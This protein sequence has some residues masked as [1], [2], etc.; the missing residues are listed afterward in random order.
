[1]AYRRLFHDRFVAAPRVGCRPRRDRASAA[2]TAFHAFCWTQVRPAR[3]A[4]QPGDHRSQTP[5]GRRWT[6]GDQTTSSELCLRTFALTVCPVANCGS[7]W[8]PLAHRPTSGWSRRRDAV[9]SREQLAVCGQVRSLCSDRSGKGMTAL[10][11]S[12]ATLKRDASIA[13]ARAIAVGKDRSVQLIRAGRTP[14][15]VVAGSRTMQDRRRD[16]LW[17]ELEP[18]TFLNLSARQPEDRHALFD[19]AEPKRF[20]PA[21]AAGDVLGFSLRG[22]PGRTAPRLGGRSLRQARRGDGCAFEPTPPGSRSER[23]FPLLREKGLAWLMRQGRTRGFEVKPKKRS[24]RGST[25]NAGPLES[26]RRRN[27]RIRQST[28]KER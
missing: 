7:I 13:A 6:C 11:F 24:D 19:L 12:R 17:R 14:P 1:M 9:V 22:K 8:T 15:G 4:A 2:Q 26:P 5:S 20:A 16:F 10:Y 18:G 27:C 28:M 3:P 21:L 25:N 23:R